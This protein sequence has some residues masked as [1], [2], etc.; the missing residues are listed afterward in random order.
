M[1]NPFNP[2]FGVRPEQFLGRDDIVDSFINAITN[3]NSPWR[4]TLLVGVRGSGKTAILSQ[5][6]AKVMNSEIFVVSVSPE[7]DFLDNVLGQ[8]YKQMSKPKLKGLPQLKSLSLGYGIALSFEKDGDTPDFTKTFRYQITNML[9]IVQKSG[10][11]VVFLIDESQKHNEGLRTFIGTYQHLLR[12]EYPVSLVMAGL[13]EVVS[14]ILNDDVLTFFRRANQV[15]LK[16]V[17]ISLV[18]QEYRNVFSRENNGIS[19]ILLKEAAIKTYGYPYLIQL[20]GYYLWENIHAGYRGDLLLQVLVSAKDRLFQNVHQLVYDRLSVRD[21]EFLFSMADDESQ[22]LS[23]DILVRLGK[24]K[25]YA[26][27]YRARL[28]SRGIIVSTGHG[29]LGYAYPYMREFL[30]EKKSELAL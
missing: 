23:K 3:I 5:I 2:S 12:E 30:L 16:N 24:G 1:N 14:E 28:I 18:E 26:S 15:Y 22:S 8:L 29:T 4:S 7:S 27:M 6:Q 10:K 25:S 17:G 11:S 19:D 21:K 9:D 20:V 13:P